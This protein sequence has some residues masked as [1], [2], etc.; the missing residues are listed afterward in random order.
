MILAIFNPLH[1]EAASGTPNID[2]IIDSDEWVNGES[3]KVRMTFGRNI[4]LTTLFTETDMYFLAEIPHD[5]ADDVINRNPKDGDRNIKHDYFGIEFD[6][7]QDDAIMGTPRSPD[8]MYLIDYS[9]PDGVDMFSHSNL[10]FEDE[11]YDGK[12]NGAGKSGQSN[13]YLIYEIRKPLSSLDSKGYDVS[14]KLRDKFYIMLA[15][16]DDRNIHS[17]AGSVN[18][19]I[20]NTVF[21]EM[22]VG[23]PIIE[24]QKE[25][26]AFGSIILSIALIFFLYQ[27]KEK[28]FAY[29]VTQ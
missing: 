9:V 2:G 27:K 23:D 25:I 15:F 17:A 29:P 26:I 16:W 24:I 21:M 8:D 14:L 11:L 6:L 13:G 7:N 3:R 4:I 12:N 28:R 20:G 18:I 1:V 5:S 19:Q 22:I 10:V